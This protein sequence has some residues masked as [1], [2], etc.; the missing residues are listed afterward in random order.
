MQ[1]GF[2]DLVPIGILAALMAVGISLLFL[3][4]PLPDQILTSA[5][6]DLI[7]LADTMVKGSLGGFFGYVGGRVPRG[8]GSYAGG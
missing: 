7:E 2:G 3:L 5:Q 8:S 6:R 1:F 4:S